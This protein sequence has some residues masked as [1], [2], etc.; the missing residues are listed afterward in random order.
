MTSGGETGHGGQKDFALASGLAGEVGGLKALADLGVAAEGAGAA[1]GDVAEDQVEEA[2]GA[3][4][5]GGV[6]VEGFGLGGG[7]GGFEAGGQGLEAA[8][9]RIGREE[10]GRGMA[11]GEDEGLAAGRGAG[12]PDAG[13]VGVGGGG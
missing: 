11:R 12:V 9:V 13:R 7:A 6:G 10:V 3:R 5:G 1:A 8:E 4:E 2:F